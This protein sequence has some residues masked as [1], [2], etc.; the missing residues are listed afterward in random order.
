MLSVVVPNYN[1]GRYL[2][3]ALRALLDQ[4]RPPLEII[5]VDDGSTD[6]SCAIVERLSARHPSVRLIRQE[7][8]RGVNAALNRG[9]GEAR[10]E[11]VCFPA[12][13]DLV[14]RDFVSRS[15]EILARY[16]AASL[17]FSDL[18]V[19][20]GD[21]GVVQRFPLFLSA[22]AC[23]LVPADMERVLKRNYFNFPSHSIIYRRGALLEVGG[24]P[25]DL[26]WLADWFVNYVLALRHGA[27]Y[28]PEI[29][30]FFRISTGSYSALGPRQGAVQR[31]LIYRAVELFQSQEFRD[32]ARSVRECA[33]VP[34]FSVRLLCWLLASPRHRQHLTARLAKR[35][36][37]RSAWSVLAR[38]MPMPIRHGIR[39][40]AGIPIRQRTAGRSRRG[41]E[42]A[43]VGPTAIDSAA[44]GRQT[45]SR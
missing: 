34:E 42:G 6:E 3:A 30:A 31:Q 24:F 26:R 37:L 15:L 27:C 14:T 38:G 9:L 41:R 39:W 10:G 18:G 1:H 20:R 4:S 33:V 32:V 13:D 16:P 12:A 29:L 43:G 44:R 22:Q 5:V 19:M 45:G 11:Y 17:C 25:E 21:S 28:V 8:R 40:L 23:F 7:R 35:L 2:G 36:L